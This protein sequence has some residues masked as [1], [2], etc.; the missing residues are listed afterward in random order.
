[1]TPINIQTLQFTNWCSNAFAHYLF[2]TLSLNS[3]NIFVLEGGFIIKCT[4]KTLQYVLLFFK[5]HTLCLYK[6]LIDIAVEDTPKYKQRFRI[7]YI[8]SSLQY[9]SKF[10]I[11]V[12]TDELNYLPS[13][14]W[15]FSSAGWL[16]REVWDL[17]G[18]YFRQHP[19]LRRIL[20]DYGFPC[21]PL[22]KDFPLSGFVEIYYS[23]GK[24]RIVTEPVELA[25]E[26]R[27]FTI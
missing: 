25:Q 16:E 17:F 27:V 13:V 12:V 3:A 10:I 18:I 22:R 9:A 26:Y 15:I 1:M 2:Y 4:P 5:K 19:N 14:A 23:L 11:S 21:H 24:K 6:Q 8:L 7:N 20:T